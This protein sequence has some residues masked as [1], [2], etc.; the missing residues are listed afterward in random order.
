MS[1]T[2]QI[3]TQRKAYVKGKMK[4]ISLE[5][6]KKVMDLLDLNYT[7]TAIIEELEKLNIFKPRDISDI[8]KH[9]DSIERSAKFS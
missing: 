3:V 9:F 7:T 4:G 5:D 1:T 8:K 2:K 6:E